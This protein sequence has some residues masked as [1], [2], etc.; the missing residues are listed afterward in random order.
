VISLEIGLSEKLVG[1]S[2]GP[3]LA[4]MPWLANIAEISALEKNVED[5]LAVL[6]LVPVEL[7]CLHVILK[8]VDVFKVSRHVSRQDQLNDGSADF[9]VLVV[10]EVFKDV[11]FFVLQH[12]KHERSVVVLQDRHV[13]VIEGKLSLCIYLKYIVK[14]RMIEIMAQSGGEECQDVQMCEVLLGVQHS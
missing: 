11:A 5:H 3:V 13:I 12:S 4:E 10:I 8:L 2:I 6:L 9:L 7:G 14:S 1:N